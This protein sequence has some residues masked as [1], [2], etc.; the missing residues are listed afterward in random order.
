MIDLHRKETLSGWERG[1]HAPD[2]AHLERL[3]AALEVHWTEFFCRDD[4]GPK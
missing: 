1:V 4:S 2:P 3:A